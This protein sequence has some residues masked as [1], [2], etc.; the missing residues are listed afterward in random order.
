[1]SLKGDLV[2]PLKPMNQPGG[3]T[4]QMTPCT[5]KKLPV[6]FTNLPYQ[7]LVRPP[8]VYPTSNDESVVDVGFPKLECNP[9]ALG[10]VPVG[11]FGAC[12]IDQPPPNHGHEC[13][14]P[15][16]VCPLDFQ[17]EQTPMVLVMT[18]LA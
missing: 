18:G 3:G 11:M 14:C 13:F 5:L 8:L 17:D 16:S 1:M 10:N 7:Q 6:A 2:K 12:L 4:D 15:E 9:A